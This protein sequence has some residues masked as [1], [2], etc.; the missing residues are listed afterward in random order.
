MKMRIRICLGGESGV[1]LITALS[2][3]ALFSLLGSAYLGY[4]LAETN[5]RT[6]DLRMVRGQEYARAGLWAAV[7][8]LEGI[9]GSGGVVPAELDFEF[10]VYVGGDDGVLAHERYFGVAHVRILDECSKVNV[11]HASIAILRG[12]GFDDETARAIVTSRSSRQSGGWFSSLDELVDRGLVAEDLLEKVGRDLLTVHSVADHGNAR[13]FVNVNSASGPVLSAVL[14]LD[15]KAS[16]E[17]IK[18]R[19]LSSLVDLRRAAQG[20]AAAPTTLQALPKEASFTSRAYRLVSTGSLSWRAEDGRELDSF[21]SEVEGVVVFSAEGGVK[22][23]FWNEAPAQVT[24]E[25][26][27][28]ESV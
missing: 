8:E 20:A 18:A 28:E 6:Y 25:A 2:I 16:Q 24:S 21:G 13:G 12:L 26:V 19:P 7:G 1:A 3:L 15:P 22:V 10:P 5:E 4:M 23:T 14:G 11:N 17:I 27:S 9:V